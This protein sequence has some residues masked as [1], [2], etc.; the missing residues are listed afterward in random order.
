MGEGTVFIRLPNS[1]ATASEKHATINSPC[2][3]SLNCKLEKKK[4]TFALTYKAFSKL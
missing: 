2:P 4:I 3:L 1:T